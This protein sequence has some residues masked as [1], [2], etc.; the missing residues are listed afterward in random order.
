MSKD[1]NPNLELALIILPHIFTHQFHNIKEM[2]INFKSA[3]PQNKSGPYL[4]LK[5]LTTTARRYSLERWRFS[6]QRDGPKQAKNCLIRKWNEMVYKLNQ[7]RCLRDEHW[8]W[9]CLIILPLQSQ[10]PFHHPDVYG[11][12]Q[13][14]KSRKR[15]QGRFI[16]SIGKTFLI[17]MCQLILRKKV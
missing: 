8:F 4:S 6:E 10:R 14:P 15:F 3:K 11:F 17:K 1:L 12:D 5:F 16:L 7:M 9:Y 13:Y 2:F